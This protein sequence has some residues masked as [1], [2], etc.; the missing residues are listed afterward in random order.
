MDRA[1]GGDRVVA[2]LDTNVLVRFFV[3]TPPEQAER[4]RNFI[5]H[6]NR[7]LLADLIVAET[8]YV[9]EKVYEAPRPLVAR[10]LRS[11]IAYRTIVTE[12]P[13]VLL[14]SLQI[15]EDARLSFADAYLIARAEAADDADVASFG[16]GIDRVKTI[17]RIEP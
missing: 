14:R 7:L 17:R 12:N 1:G 9:L 8:V 13:A 5:A 15:Y 10:N 11:T 2:F 16:K 4:A 3:G 6:G